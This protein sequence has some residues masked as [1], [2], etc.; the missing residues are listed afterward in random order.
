MKTTRI[1]SVLIAIASTGIL[2]AC[3]NSAQPPL[4]QA[5]AESRYASSITFNPPS[6]LKMT[7]NSNVNVAVS[8]RGYSGGFKVTGCS[9]KSLGAHCTWIKY[10]QA[11]YVNATPNYINTIEARIYTGGSTLMMAEGEIGPTAPSLD[12]HFTIKDKNGNSAVYTATAP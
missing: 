2:A 10:G 11:C 12:C 8:E 1:F 9:T 4:S 3:A 6:P 5:G 7:L